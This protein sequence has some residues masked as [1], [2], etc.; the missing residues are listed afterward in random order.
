MAKRRIFIMHPVANQVE[1]PTQKI[2]EALE[3]GAVPGFTGSVTVHIRLLP[4][5]AHEFEF[6]SE[7]R[8]MQQTNI[9][10]EESTPLVTNDRVAKVRRKVAENS[11]RFRM[12]TKLS[13]I[14]GHFL[15]GDLRKFEVIEVENG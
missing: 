7:R 13:Q 1:I 5:A 6:V 2:E 3:K 14:V 15:D 11:N 10:R 12:G 4:T 8:A 9:S